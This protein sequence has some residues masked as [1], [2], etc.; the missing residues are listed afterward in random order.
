MLEKLN[1][2]NADIDAVAEQAAGDNN[3]IAELVEGLTAKSEDYRYN[4]SKVLHVIGEQQP[5]I[6]YPYWDEFVSLMDSANSYHRM[7]AVYHIS[8]LVAADK[9][10]RFENIFGKYFR[11]LDDPSVIVSTY[12]A[13]AAGRIALA[14]PTLQKGITDI[15]LAVDKTHHPP[16]RK[17]L[18]KSGIIESFDKYMKDYPDKSAIFVFVK[19]QTESESPKTRNLAR[20]FIK[21]WDR[22]VA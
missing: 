21:K 6:L 15:L 17:E 1:H 13:Q 11:L 18:I 20:S 2:K 14:K 12:V 5:Q 10:N 7:A 9:A 19:K 8:N 4:C 16:G 22:R 3:I